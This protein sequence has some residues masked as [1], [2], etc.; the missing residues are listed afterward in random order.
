MDGGGRDRLLIQSRPPARRGHGA[1]DRARYLLSAPSSARPSVSQSC[2]RAV[3]AGSG[4]YIGRIRPLV[5]TAAS[6]EQ[7]RPS[8]VGPLAKT[9]LFRQPQINSIYSYRE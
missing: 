5:V 6:G 8:D 7:T 1:D 9:P 3:L 4:T 2:A